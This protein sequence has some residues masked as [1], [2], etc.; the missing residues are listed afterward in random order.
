VFR[1][2]P[3]YIL[4]NLFI[5]FIDEKIVQVGKEQFTAKR[6]LLA[7]GSRPRIPK[8]AEQSDYITN[9]EVFSLKE[10]PRKLVI[11]GAGPI[12]IELA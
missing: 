12:G 7:T 6:I 2:N 11:V 4:Q 1:A 3:Y 10:L 8:A 9:E 5:S